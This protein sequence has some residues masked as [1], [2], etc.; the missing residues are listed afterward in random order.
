MSNLDSIV[1]HGSA[2]HREARDWLLCLTSGQATARD[3]NA[4]K[5]WCGQ[6]RAHAQAF[7]ETRLLWENLGPA[8]RAVSQRELSRTTPPAEGEPVRDESRS[9]VAIPARMSRR[10]FLGAAVA[11]SAACLLLRPPLRLWPGWSDWMADYRTDTGEQR[12]IQAAPGVVVE[13]NTQT[14]INRLASR[15][16]QLGMEL[17]SGEVQI[18][19]AAQLAEPFTLLAGAGHVH[20][21]PGTQCNIRCS[22][23]QVQVTGLD[24][25]TELVYRGRKVT[26]QAGERVSYSEQTIAAVTIVDTELAMA[27]RRRVLIFDNQPLSEVVNEINRYRPGKI[28][29]TN[30]TLAARKVHARFSLNQLADVA[31]LIHDAFDARV[32][33][34]PGGIVLLS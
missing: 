27:W 30:G 16:Q 12:Q 20:L 10:A 23:K 6:S 31:T 28:V 17:V 34:L 29:I 24:G 22:D 19:T 13:M 15:G 32:T 7:A 11:A 14:T 9:P 4:F 3:A 33:S 21:P 5:Q 18:Q 8:A 1:G 25:T 26:L 2:L